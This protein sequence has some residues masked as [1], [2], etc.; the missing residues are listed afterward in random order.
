MAKHP[1]RTHLRAFKPSVKS[2]NQEQIVRKVV[3]IKCLAAKV[4]LHFFKNAI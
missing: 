4:R 1:D 3:F 2:V